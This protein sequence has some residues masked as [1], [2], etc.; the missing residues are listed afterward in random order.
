M[1]FL[2]FYGF[3]GDNPGSLIRLA[4]LNIHRRF[5]HYR[6]MPFSESYHRFK[7]YV[8]PVVRDK[9]IRRLDREFWEPSGCESHMS[10]L[11]IGCGTGLFLA[12][13]ESKG[14]GD[15]L[16]IDADPGLKP[17]IP[18]PV[19]DRFLVTDIFAFLDDIDAAGTYDR[20]AVFD[21]LEHFTVE[22]GLRLLRGI[23]GVLRPGGKVIVKVP[24]AASPWGLQFQFGDLTHKAAY[25]PESLRQLAIAAGFTCSACYP[26]YLGSPSRQLFDRAFHGI[27]DRV[28]MARPQIW[29][30]NFFA[31]LEPA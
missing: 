26:H 23:G 10:V 12:Y 24:N 29:L 5:G 18:E 1:I 16:G 3:G 6:T 20:V 4:L 2:S 17:F 28:L 19:R 7:N 11:D 13:L 31:I 22:E 25:S 30:P 14:V 27:L 21:V 8:T 15:F 9:H